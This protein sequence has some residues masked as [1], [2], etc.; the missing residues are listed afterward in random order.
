MASIDEGLSWSVNTLRNSRYKNIT[1]ALYRNADPAVTV[2]YITP[3]GWDG[4]SGHDSACAGA[5]V[6]GWKRDPHGF[7]TYANRRRVY[8]GS[9]TITN[10]SDALGTSVD[11]TLFGGALGNLLPGVSGYV[12]RGAL[13]LIGGALIVAAAVLAAR[14]ESLGR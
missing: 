5:L 8:A 4:R 12:Q 1:S 7:D 14:S 9:G 6:A 3:S 2:G 10:S 13:L 11:A